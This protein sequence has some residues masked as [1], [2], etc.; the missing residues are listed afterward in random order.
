MGTG[1][2]SLRKKADAARTEEDAGWQQ[3][4]KRWGVWGDGSDVGREWIMSWSV[5]VQKRVLNI[6][7]KTCICYFPDLW[8]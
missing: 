8:I 3:Q 1:P 2:E 6:V 5:G 4:K 7:V